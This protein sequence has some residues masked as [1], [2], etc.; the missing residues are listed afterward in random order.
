[1]LDRDVVLA[2][3]S[4]IDRC[5]ARI[6]EVRERA[7]LRP[8]DV[9]DLTAL[10]L[11]RAVQAAIDLAS[12]IVSAESLGLPSAAGD[13]FVILA[14]RGVLDSEMAERLRRMVGFRNIA[15]HEYSR[16]DPD[17]VEGIVKDRLGDLRQLM[18]VARERLDSTPDSPTR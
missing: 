7:E 14:E 6:Q 18:R 11:Q 10:N 4:T 5:L 3:L 1:M 12:H 8:I 2:K 17:I 16:L 9:T 13:S 15:I